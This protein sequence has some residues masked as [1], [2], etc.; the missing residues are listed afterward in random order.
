MTDPRPLYDIPEDTIRVRPRPRRMAPDDPPGGVTGPRRGTYVPPE[1]LDET[2]VSGRTSPAR[3]P[4]D[5]IEDTVVSRR[6]RTALEAEAAAHRAP[7]DADAGDRSRALRST[8]LPD[9]LDRTVVSGRVPGRIA[10]VPDV[11]GFDDIDQALRLG[12][13]SEETIVTRQRT[14]GVRRSPAPPVDADAPVEP[15]RAIAHAAPRP[16]E[17]SPPTVRTASAGQPERA[18]Y[19]PRPAEPV[20]IDRAPAPPRTPARQPGTPARPARRRSRAALVAGGVLLA[21][22]AAAAVALAALLGIPAP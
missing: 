4:D 16:A 9:D 19:R 22:V 20:R 8:V 1:H 14:G 6:R 18:I 12:A 11:S 21:A 3:L 7:A 10:P 2:V 5:D 13:A 17:A 15:P